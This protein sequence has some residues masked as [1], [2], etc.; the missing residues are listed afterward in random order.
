MTKQKIEHPFK[1]PENFFEDFKLEMTTRFPYKEKRTRQH[2]LVIGLMKYAAIIVISF[3]LGRVSVQIFSAHSNSDEVLANGYTID[4]IYSQID[5][6]DLDT[7]LVE[8]NAN[9]ILAQ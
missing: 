7:Y 2:S 5:E 6:A 9:E 3:V 4:E 1:V 8:T